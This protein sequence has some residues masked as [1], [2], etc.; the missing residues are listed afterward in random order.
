M[1]VQGLAKGKAGSQIASCQDALA[2][3]SQGGKEPRG[4]RESSVA[5]G[6]VWP[7][8]KEEGRLQNWLVGSALGEAG[9]QKQK[10]KPNKTKQNPG[11]V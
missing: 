6:D 4:R 8:V 3:I 5:F 7:W 9:K 1:A 11:W 10:P 2:Y